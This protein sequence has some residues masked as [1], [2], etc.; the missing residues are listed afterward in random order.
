MK[1]RIEDFTI[2]F[3]HGISEMH[4]RWLPFLWRM[5]R[6]LDLTT[7]N[8]RT[9]LIFSHINPIFQHHPTTAF[10][11]IAVEIQFLDSHAALIRA[12]TGMVPQGKTELNPSVNTHH[13]HI[14]VL[15]GEEWR[16]KPYQNTK[17]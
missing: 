7:V 1:S 11:G 9:R 12:I 14:A 4:G 15:H 6:S 13:T 3:S 10:V 2:N 17:A 8:Q 16:K 5:G